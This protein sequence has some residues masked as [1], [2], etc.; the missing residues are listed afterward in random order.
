MTLHTIIVNQKTSTR[1]SL[2][3]LKEDKDETTL[4]K[5]QNTTFIQL[6]TVYEEDV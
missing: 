3:P 5:Q 4:N 6:K 1:N 2:T